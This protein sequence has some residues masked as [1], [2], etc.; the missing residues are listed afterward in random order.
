AL[1]LAIGF[2]FV[3]NSIA[4]TWTAL[5]LGLASR[6]TARAAVGALLRV[7][8]IPLPPFMIAIAL[9]LGARVS[10]AAALVMSE[11]TWVLL[12][13]L[14]S[15]LFYEQSRKRLL[16]EQCRQ[17]ACQSAVP[18]ITFADEPE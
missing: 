7:L 8:F 10:G 6:N 5:W 4:L 11:A 1:K 16:S 3:V 12:S 13:G 14:L 18:F 17:L 2:L 15:Y 9:I